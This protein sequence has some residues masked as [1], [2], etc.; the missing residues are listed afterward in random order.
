MILNSWKYC[1][2]ARSEWVSECVVSWRHIS[3]RRLFR[4]IQVNTFV[5]DNGLFAR[6]IV[7][8]WYESRKRKARISG[9]KGEL[10][11][12]YT[13]GSWWA[14]DSVS[15]WCHVADTFHARFFII[16]KAKV[17]AALT[18]TYLVFSKY[19]QLLWIGLPPV[20][21]YPQHPGVI[22]C[23]DFSK[24]YCIFSTCTCI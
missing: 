7:E 17:L 2:Y 15:P 1:Q 22:Q 19:D 24:K 21:G 20:P 8:L 14:W 10:V 16:Y 6:D 9:Q 4:A 23:R 13:A 3:T 18:A 11:E 12:S 5:W